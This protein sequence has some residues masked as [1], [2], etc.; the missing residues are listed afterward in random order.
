VH[1]W[2]SVMY[3]RQGFRDWFPGDIDIVSEDGTVQDRGADVHSEAFRDFMVDV[4]VGIAR[5]YGV[6][7]IHLD[8]IRSMGNCYCERCRAQFAEQFGK[9]LS[10]ATD[11]DWVRWQSQAIGDIV[12]RTAEGVREVNPDARISCAVFSN[13]SGG[14]SQG[15]QAP[16]WANAGLV[17][18][19]MPMDYKMQTIELKASEEQWL[20]ALDDD[21]KLCTG[22]SV[23][24]SGGDEPV[25]RPPALV[26]EQ[27]KMLRG[28]GIHGYNLFRLGFVEGDLLEAFA[29]EINEEDAVPFYR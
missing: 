15:Q 17:D 28:M 25:S 9:P 12:L 2:F 21:D 6:D 23:Y 8:Y 14:A 5:D 18:I 16:A 3:R 29:E 7:G 1:P 26:S 20:E 10:E 11:E 19:V 4:M 24:A 13:M 27:V 22:I